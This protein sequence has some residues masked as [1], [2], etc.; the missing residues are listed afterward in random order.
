MPRPPIVAILGHVD[1]G[2]TS[3]L[4]YIRQSHIA[5]K[6]YGAITQKIGAYEIVTKI[7][8]YKNNKIT[9]I[10]TPGH[11]AFSALRL[12]GANVADLAL[13]LIDA[14]DSVKPQ[15]IESISHIQAAKIPYIVVINKIDLPEANPEKVKNDLLKHKVIVEEK[16]G[17]IPV[18]NISAKTG[19]G[20]N[21]L[22][23][24]ILLLSSDLDLNYK[25]DNPLQAVVIETKKDRRGVVTSVI[26][27][28]G[29]LKI[30][31]TIYA[32]GIK[33]KI[34]SLINDLGKPMSEVYPSTPVEIIG[35]K[36]PPPVGELITVSPQ[37]KGDKNAA[38]IP[39]KKTFNLQT[40]LSVKPKE[41]KIRL[42]IKTDT[43]G[44]LETITSA[45]ADKENIEVILSMVGDINKSDIFLA[46]T[47]QA[48][49]IGF[50]TQVKSEI[51]QLAKQE[52]VV[53]KNYQIIF[54]LLEEL[55][56]VTN[57][58]KLKEEAE[59]QTKGE[60]KIL[61]TFIIEK[62]KIYGVKVTKGKISLNDKVDILREN[63]PVGKTKIVSM[64]IRAKK[65]DEVKKGQEAG[66]I[67]FPLLD[68]QI[69]DMIKSVL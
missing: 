35:F 21:D 20:V 28:D 63:K 44:S 22:L 39:L 23:E 37:K 49:V 29:C 58:L 14:K 17:Q 13:L 33:A 16:G 11:E 15:T 57:L 67:F 24:T 54:E 40:V 9:F 68:I 27:K 47:S 2:K 65:V 45:L 25:K 34:R 5:K 30:G 26:V 66:I 59:K 53:I 6:E 18:V 56:E 7:K 61:A 1:H 43:F 52:K 38:A 51:K 4:D 12:R 8:G 60:A 62:E 10:D 42:I 32:N 55:D 19:Q 41:K 36:N 3:L 48:I 50:N 64:K 31:Q 69:G 46:K